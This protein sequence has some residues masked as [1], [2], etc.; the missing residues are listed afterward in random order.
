MNGAAESH[1]KPGL[2]S[3]LDEPVRRYFTHALGGGAPWGPGSG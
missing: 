2:V 3:E 1:F